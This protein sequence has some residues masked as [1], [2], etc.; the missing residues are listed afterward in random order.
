MLSKSAENGF[1]AASK[2]VFGD[3]HTFALANQIF[4]FEHGEWDVCEG[5]HWLDVMNQWEVLKMKIRPPA[6]SKPPPDGVDERYGDFT[7]T[8]SLDRPATELDTLWGLEI[9]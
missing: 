3:E 2:S 7:P 9:S 4:I 5:G 1:C 8:D 6:G